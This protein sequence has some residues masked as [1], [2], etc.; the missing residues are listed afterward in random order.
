[1]D[2]NFDGPYFCC[3]LCEDDDDPD[4][5][6]RRANKKLC[7]R[8]NRAEQQAR[9][10][11]LTVEEVNGILRVQRDACGL[12]GEEPGDA[13]GSVDEA[14]RSFW[15]IDHDHACCGQGGSCGRCV[16]GMLC[17]M[18]NTT[19]LPAYERLPEILRDSPRFNAYLNSPP[20]RQPDA[21]PIGR[22]TGGPRGAFSAILDAYFNC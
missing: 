7:V 9:T 4:P 8:C 6:H 16:R 22:D 19:R 1:M 17:R 14:G 18:C 15:N 3:V 11:S 12:C 13:F 10:Y 21:R 2:W 20:A 5:R